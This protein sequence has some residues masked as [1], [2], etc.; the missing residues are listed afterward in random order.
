MN[1][2][3]EAN[4]AAMNEMKK[5]YEDLVAEEAKEEE[6]EREKKQREE[7]EKS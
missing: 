7:R 1:D 4:M 3:L 6:E 2:E 5:N